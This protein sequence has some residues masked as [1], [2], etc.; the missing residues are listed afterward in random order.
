MKIGDHPDTLVYAFRVGPAHAPQRIISMR[1]QRVAAKVRKAH[2]ARGETTGPLR[3]V[4]AA[5]A[6]SARFACDEGYVPEG[7]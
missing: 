4:T 6:E 3:K 7:W 2:K 5:R 1:T